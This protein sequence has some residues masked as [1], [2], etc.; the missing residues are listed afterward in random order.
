MF[1]GEHLINCAGKMGYLFPLHKHTSRRTKQDPNLS[2]VKNIS[3]WI[4]DVNIR[5]QR[6]NTLGQGFFW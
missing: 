1:F 2:P 5:K 3:N 6:G 4:K